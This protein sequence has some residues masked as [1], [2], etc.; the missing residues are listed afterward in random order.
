VWGRPLCYLWGC[1]L[2]VSRTT[3][4]VQA[5]SLGGGGRG[6][7]GP[8]LRVPA[9]PRPAQGPLAGVPATRCLG[10][11]ATGLGGGGRR[12]ARRAPR[13][14]RPG[15]P[16]PGPARR[17]MADGA[18]RPPRPSAGRG[19]TAPLLKGPQRRAGG[20]GRTAGAGGG[21]AVG[22]LRGPASAPRL[23]VARA[24]PVR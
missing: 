17:G 16:P 4:A 15:P 18:A 2:S 6:A 9:P 1:G 5:P 8:A 19:G 24:S 10:R 20:R 3:G 14:A 13:S 7:G 12:D 22:R 11:R 21:A 23:A